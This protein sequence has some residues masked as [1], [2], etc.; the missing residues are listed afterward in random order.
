MAIYRYLIIGGGM[1]GDAALRGIRAVDVRGSV[2]MFSDEPDPPYK[3]PLLSK[4]LWRGKTID[5]AWCGT[6]RLDV[7]LNLRTK[8]VSL[9]PVR[10]T[11]CDSEGRE[12]TYGKLLLATGGTPRRLEFNSRNV[13]Y[14][15]TMQ[16][17][18]RLREMAE[19]G[20]RFAV[21]GA[22]FIGSEIA[23]ALAI[24]GKEVV[25][26]F[27]ETA[28]GARVFPPALSQYLSRFYREKGIELLAEERVIGIAEAESGARLTLEGKG[29]IDVDGVIAGVGILANVE[30]ARGAKLEIAEGGI[31]VD[32][33]L[34]TAAPDVY[35]AGDVAAVFQPALGSYQRVEH[36]DNALK[37][38]E[39]AGR[40]MAGNTTPYKH[41]PFFYSDLFEIGYEAVGEL[42][43]R[44]DIFADWLEPCQKGVIYYLKSGRVRGVLTWNLYDRMDFA[45]DLIAE[46]GPFKPADLKNRIDF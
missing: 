44:S 37:M 45:R 9:D 20:K 17:Y 4:G 16:D 31:A 41:L 6:D 3:R 14:Y 39:A 25:L 23:A 2:G 46:P 26:I 21:I 43:A 12:H 11:V 19:R 22:G 33:C 40:S 1:A 7:D 30:L 28:I 32:D 10:K 29:E 34:K 18:L 13:L 8:I 24:N 35:A 42:D 27:P 38:G 36:E 5:K 15:R